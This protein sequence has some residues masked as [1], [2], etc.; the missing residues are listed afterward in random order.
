MMDHMIDM[1]AGMGVIGL[2]IAIVLVLGAAALA[3]YLFFGG[4]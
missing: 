3:K 1:M 4:R 2:L